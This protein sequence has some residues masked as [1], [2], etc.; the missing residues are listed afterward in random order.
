MAFK[1][2]YGKQFI[3]EEDT[4]AVVDA[5]HSDF[6][7]QG[8]EIATFEK[9]FAD[10]AKAGLR[11]DSGKIYDIDPRIDEVLDLENN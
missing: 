8:P 4:K 1:I 6:L 7:T 11:K 5:L 10:A 3:S 2:P 9:A